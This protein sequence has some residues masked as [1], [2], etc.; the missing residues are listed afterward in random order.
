MPSDDKALAY[1]GINELDELTSGSVLTTDR[2]PVWDVSTNKMKWAKV[3]AINAAG[4]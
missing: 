1:K 3:S 4:T 2:I